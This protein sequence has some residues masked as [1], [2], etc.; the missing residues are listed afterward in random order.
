MKKVLGILAVSA[1]LVGFSACGGDEDEA[2]AEVTVKSAIVVAT[3]EAVTA[4]GGTLD[5]DCAIKAYVKMN[6]DDSLIM[7]E[8]IGSFGDDSLDPAELGM[9]E[10]GIA[11]LEE[12]SAC[13]SME[14]GATEETT[15]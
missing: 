12:V 13:I 9:S 4:M 15:P 10:D 1:A 8:N 6:A 3:E 2:E 7:V 5:I 11:I 14:E